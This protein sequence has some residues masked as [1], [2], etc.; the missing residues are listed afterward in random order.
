MAAECRQARKA[1]PADA[2]IGRERAAPTPV[3]HPAA[4]ASGES[5]RPGRAGFDEPQQ[6]Q[7][8]LD[9]GAVEEFE[10][11]EFDKGDIAPRQFDFERAAVMR[12]PEE[13]R[14]LLQSACRLR[15]SP[16]RARRYSGPGRP[17]RERVTSCGRSADWRSVQRFLVKR[18]DAKIDHAICGR[19]DRL[20]RAVIAV[21]RDDVGRRD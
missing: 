17:R 9:M 11:A 20:G 19:E 5:R 16:A 6:G 2:A 3:R 8:V 10:A 13:N 18:S 7:Q 4:A 15:G 21:E 14:L 12:R 1:D